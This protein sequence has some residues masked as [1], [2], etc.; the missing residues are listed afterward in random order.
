MLVCEAL[1]ERNDLRLNRHVERRCRLVG[2]DEFRVSGERERNYDA[3]AHAARKLVRVLFGADLGRGNSGFAKKFNRAR[4]GLS[5]RHLRAMRPDGFNELVAHLHEGVERRER[6]LEDRADRLPAQTFAFALGEVVYAPAFEPEFA[7]RDPRARREEPDQGLSGHGLPGT[8]FAHHAENFA[9]GNG[10]VD[11]VERPEG[12]AAGGD[13][14]REV[15]DLQN[16]GLPR[17][18]AQFSHF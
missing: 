3:L 9:F 6:I 11:A 5:A 4:F 18:A 1:Q 8:G 13:F 15:F 14:N 17:G 12:L 10:E 7:G 2:N 16:G